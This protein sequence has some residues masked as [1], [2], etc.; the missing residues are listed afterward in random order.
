MALQKSGVKELPKNA[1]VLSEKEALKYQMDV[2]KKWKTG[3]EV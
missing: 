3:S 2:V 1:V